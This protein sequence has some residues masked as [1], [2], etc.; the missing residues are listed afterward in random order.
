MIEMKILDRYILKKF[1]VI[2]LL[3][4]ITFLL[5]FNIVD[6]IEKIDKFIRAKMTLSA[7]GIYYLY[8]FPFFINIAI[9][10]SLLL[11]SVFTIGILSKNNELAAIKAS[12]ISLYRLSAP[13]LLI[14]LIFSIGSFFFED[15][16]VIPASRK[17]IETE[18]IKLKRRRYTKK[19][20]FTN[21][22][23]QDSPTC[24]IVISKFLTKNNTA[25][26][27]TIQYTSNHKL[28]QRIDARKMTWIPEK[29]RW[30]V[31]DFK[32]RNFDEDGNET[33]SS[34]FT[35]SLFQFNLKPEDIIQTSLK[36]D[37]MRFRELSDFIKR[38]KESGN[39]PRKWA[40]NLH[41]KI[42]FS[43]T[44]FIVILFGLPLAAMKHKKGISFGARMSLLVIF[45]YYSF[46]K[47]GQVL[48]YKGILSPIL[49][50][51]LGNIIFLIAGSRLLYKIR[52]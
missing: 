15:T 38:L 4:L 2:F 49:S 43:F 16:L 42:A 17:R 37:A 36:P 23:Y 18:Q 8:Q 50:V 51:W 47:F 1:F 52:Q 30:K 20:I 25:T 32:V 44:N 19:K 12:G 41:F 21:I 35:D 14:G 28:V 7:V 9:P 45:T 22:M 40:V 13:L 31:L 11:A 46:I 6:V 3:S 5:I 33:V 27:V 34:V 29:D 26:S 48:G 24:N 39:D 10:M